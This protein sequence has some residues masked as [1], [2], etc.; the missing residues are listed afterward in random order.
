MPV[1]GYGAESAHARP[2]RRRVT[3][4]KFSKTDE[5]HMPII[6]K[7]LLLGCLLKISVYG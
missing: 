4:T 6:K 3:A 1:D 5:R 7:W 2:S